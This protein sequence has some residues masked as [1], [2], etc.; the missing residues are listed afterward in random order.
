MEKPTFKHNVVCAWTSR[1]AGTQ[2]DTINIRNTVSLFVK[3]P[4]NFE[5]QIIMTDN[6]F[7]DNVYK[8]LKEFLGLEY[9]ENIKAKFK[10]KALINIGFC[11]INKTL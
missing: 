5:C 10:D 3:F 6:K 8:Y 9:K 11:D 2:P 4:S 1:P 7:K